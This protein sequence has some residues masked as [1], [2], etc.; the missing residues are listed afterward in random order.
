M[1]TPDKFTPGTWRA[2]KPD[3]APY[4]GIHTDASYT[5]AGT[6]S[7]LCEADARLIAAAP[8]LFAFA[9]AFVELN[10][11]VSREDIAD[12]LGILLK[13]AVAALARAEGR[14]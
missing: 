8:D 5:V 2:V 1:S 13:Q 6:A 10:R 9:T 4:W 12:G 11:L 7:G 3:G 14:P